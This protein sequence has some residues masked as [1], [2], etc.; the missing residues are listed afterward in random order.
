MAVIERA[1]RVSPALRR[2]AIVAFI[3]L[4]PIAMHTAWDHYEARRLSRLVSDLRARNE[5]V[6]S[7]ATIADAES[8]DNAARYYEAAAALVDARDLYGAT[9]I[10]NRLDYSPE[11]DRRQLVQAITSWLERNREAEALLARA[12]DLP[13]E[14]YPPGTHYSYRTDRLHRL[15]K[16]ANLRTFERLEAGDAEAAAQS[17]LRQFQINRA[18]GAS[19]PSDLS[20]IGMGWAAVP[21]LREM[22]RFLAARPS[23]ASLRAVQQA[24]RGLDNDQALHQSM[25]AERAFTLGSYWDESRG[26]YARHRDMPNQAFSYVMRPLLT[27]WFVENIQLMTTLIAQA[28]QPWPERLHVNVPDRP[29]GS[30]G[31]R[32]FPFVRIPEATHTLGTSYRTRARSIATALA[33]GRSADAAIAA[34][35]FRRATGALPGALGQLVPEYLPAVP[36]DPFSGGEIRYLKAADRVVVYSVGLN[37]QDDGGEK[38]EYPVLRSGALQNRRA[39]PDFGVSIRAAPAGQR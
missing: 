24:I 27:R 19:G 37:E 9:G 20:V 31:R 8:P 38:I 17:L 6:A 39:P 5:P 10:L 2:I 23:E 13:F 7:I 1:R 16:L 32:R 12:T 36:I 22:D 15:A 4:V 21:A 26:W 11:V 25:L 35:R 28:R 34:E 30:P 18:L 33:L 29:P 14:G 3:V